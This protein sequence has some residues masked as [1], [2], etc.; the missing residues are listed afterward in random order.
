MKKMKKVILTLVALAIVI[1]TPVITASAENYE[2]SA[3]QLFDLGLFRGTDSGFNLE[4]A[5]DRAQ[6]VTMLVRL[7]G[8]EEEAFD[9]DYTHPFEDV[10][11]WASP[12]VSI[13]YE[14]GYTTGVTDTLFDPDALCSAQMYV[15]FILRALGYTNDDAIG[16]TLY[17]E[18]IDFGKKVGVV[19]DALLAGTFLRGN[20]TAVSCMALAVPTA[21][22]EYDTLLH[23]LVADGAVSTEVA[24][25]LFSRYALLG[26]LALAGAGLDNVRDFALSYTVNVETAI[27]DNSMSF[28]FEHTNLAMAGEG[29]DRELAYYQEK[30]GFTG[31]TIKE[32]Y[33]TDGYMYHGE[34]RY[35]MDSSVARQLDHYRSLSAGTYFSEYMDLSLYNFPLYAI[36]TVAKGI[37]DGLAV[38]TIELTAEGSNMLLAALIRLV[39]D[40][41]IDTLDNATCESFEIKLYVNAN[42]G[43]EKLK[44][45]TNTVS[46]AGNQMPITVDTEI[47]IIA[48]GNDVV[49][50]FPDY[51]DEY[52]ES[53]GEVWP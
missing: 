29:A 7:L 27:G 2:D 44:L 40:V 38:Y 17:N 51:L 28:Y 13:A 30:E 15:T 14:L 49:I 50:V 25:S 32:T 41:D 10:P 9:G 21:D 39:S 52:I 19:D 26:E 8:L 22:G 45:F 6:A 11:D 24:A 43:P 34:Y 37:Q 20:M 12:Y 5:P 18:A 53:D 35:P 36:K 31:N 48:T 1:C 47:E 42:G 16:D 23:K 46:I 4:S 33:I 3:Q